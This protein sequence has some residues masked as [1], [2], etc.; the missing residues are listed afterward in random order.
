EVGKSLGFSASAAK[1]AFRSAL[2]VMKEMFREFKSLGRS[3]V[4]ALEASPGEIG[5]VL[6]GRPYNAL[7]KM[8][9]KG[10]PH[11]FA[12][13]GYRTIPCDFLDFE[14]QDDPEHVYWGAGEIIIKAAKL[15]SS[16]PSLYGAFITN[17]SCGPDSFIV[18]FFRKEMGRK[19]SLTLELDNHT[20]D[21]GL[22][23]RIE[24]FVDV[25]KSYMEIMGNQEPVIDAE[26]R[27]ATTRVRGSKIEIIDSEGKVHKLNDPRV[28]V[29]IPSMLDN[30]SNASAAVLRRQ[31]NRA[32]ALPDPGEEEF[33]IGLGYTSGKECLPVA[34][35][36]GSLLKYLRERKDP[37]EL[38]VYFVPGD[39]GP[40]R[41]GSY[42]V[43]MQNIIEKLHIPNVAFLSL[44]QEDGYMGLG[45]AATLRLWQIFVITDVLEE[46]YA[47]LLVVAADREKA[48][49][50]YQ[51]AVDRVIAAIEHQRWPGLVL[52]LEN[53]AHT[54]AGIERKYEQGEKPVVSLINEMYV[55]RSNFARK[56]I[57]EKLADK[58]IILRVAGLH[59]WLY[60]VD[61]VVKKKLV[62]NSTVNNR[63]QKMLETPPKRYFEKKIKAI[64][65]KSGLY[66]SRLVD[67]EKVFD[68]AKDLI[69]PTMICESILITGT[70]ITELV[71]EVSGII[72]IQP[73]GCM[74]GRV[75]E[76]VISRKLSKMKPLHTEN[77]GVVAEVMKEFPYLPF[78]T[79]EVDGQVFPQSIEAKLE[80]FCLQVDRLHK[81]TRDI[82]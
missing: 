15:V 78:L 63:F 27:P 22:D 6:F 40:C 1:K 37:D 61:F 38:L 66:E 23:T 20:A 53:C 72:S 25:I 19:P 52:E 34:I 33:Q 49:N 8:G 12:S 68:S 51:S 18:D 29:L 11:K 24:A 57:V 46:I 47:T 13:R 32:S 44:S 45:T 55:R 14:Y 73:F 58:D 9:N 2:K 48:I 64:L 41:F 70:A 17:F 5:I 81:K 71:D 35:T 65:A 39:S 82:G 62:Q 54:L 69:P 60:Y 10:I 59:E 30:C 3:A 77:P 36:T 74:P 21:V 50:T 76:A 31:G 79:L 28:H 42:Y 26:F 7:S 16:H 75:G 80:T 4:A 43:L 56:H 67:I